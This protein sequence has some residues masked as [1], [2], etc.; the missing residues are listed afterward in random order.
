MRLNKIFQR[1]AHAPA[2][3]VEL[4]AAR[5]FRLLVRFAVLGAFVLGALPAAPEAAARAQA[6]R[7]G[8]DVSAAGAKGAKGGTVSRPGNAAKSGRPAASDKAASDAPARISTAPF[9]V[10][11]S[12]ARKLADEGKLDLSKPQSITIEGD[13]RE[14]GTLAN[15]VI[16][17]DSASNPH[18]RR[19]AQEFVAALDES[20]VLQPL[21]G[22]S[23][24]RMTFTLD[25]ERF[26]AHTASET[27][28]ETR[29]E[30]MARGYRVM[31]NM[32]RLVR[33]GT[34]EGAV[35]SG[36]KV[37]S[38]GK[39][40]LMTLDTTREAMGNLMLKQITPN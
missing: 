3:H 25:A 23:R 30:E 37:S 6:R 11:L 1:P 12:R 18:F 16:T 10:F 13:R 21:E 35:L 4:D 7:S 40:L 17:G 24:V 36:M 8:A 38:S 19:T 29:A 32:A 15:P 28:A 5:G 20:H 34:P 27:P 22:V 39:Q 2:A 33:R 14:D 26:S 9:K 31:V